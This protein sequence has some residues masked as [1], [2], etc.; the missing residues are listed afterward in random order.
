VADYGQTIQLGSY[1]T[2][3][4]SLLYEFDP[5]YRRRIGKKRGSRSHPSELRY[6]VYTSNAVYGGKILLLYSS[7]RPLL[8]LSEI[9]SQKLGV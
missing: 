7:Q 5:D 2:A 9:L 4:A 3:T 1:V 6:D 8:A